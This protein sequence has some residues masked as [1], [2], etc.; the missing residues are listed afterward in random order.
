[1]QSRY[2]LIA[3]LALSLATEALLSAGCGGSPARA[4][5]NVGATTTQGGAADGPSSSSS[6]SGSGP[7]S[8]GQGLSLKV[9]NGAKF[10][11]CMRR[12][13]IPSFPD[14]T[15][16]GGHVQLSIKGDSGSGLDPKSPKFQAAQKA[17]QGNLPGAKTGGF[18]AGG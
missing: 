14:P 16:S 2:V 8:G 10:A 13:G 11:A 17:C 1:M 7:R 4:V 18:R 6:S 12:H 5:A 3:V 9:A 15:F